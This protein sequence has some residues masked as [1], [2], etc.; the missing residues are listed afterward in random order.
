MNMVETSSSSLFRQNAPVAAVP[1]ER[2]MDESKNQINTATR[3]SGTDKDVS[4]SV[5][6]AGGSSTPSK[7]E[8]GSAVESINQ[9]VSAQMRTLNFSVDESSGKAVVKVIDFETKDI[10][11]STYKREEVLKMASAIK[12]LQDDLGSAMGLLVNNQV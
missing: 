4:A 8:L 12:R 1:A 5:Q 7:E 3:G 6:D 11:D 9:F 10:S 2:Q